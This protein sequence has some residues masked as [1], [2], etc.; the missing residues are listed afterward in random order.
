[1]PSNRGV[2]YMGPGKVEIQSIDFPKLELWFPQVRA[3]RHPQ[4]RLYEYLRQRPA[5]GPRPHDRAAG[6]DSGP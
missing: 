6:L 2:A 5:H 1:M 3:R 4:D